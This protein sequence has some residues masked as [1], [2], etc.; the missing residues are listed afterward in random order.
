MAVQAEA[1]QSYEELEEENERL[2]ALL[3]EKEIEVDDLE[4]Q[5]EDLQA[6]LAEVGRFRPQAV[7]AR[8]QDYLDWL[9]EPNTSDPTTRDA[10]AGVLFS[11]VKRELLGS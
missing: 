5:A 7:M 4:S 10:V 8:L 11:Q 1:K 9:R 3:E 6:Q 2:E